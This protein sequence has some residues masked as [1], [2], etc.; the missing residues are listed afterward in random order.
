MGPTTAPAIHALLELLSSTCGGLVFGTSADEGSEVGVE[1]EGVDR[2]ELGSRDDAEPLSLVMLESYDNRREI[3][4]Y[5]LSKSLLQASLC[6]SS[7]GR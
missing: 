7:S 6:N 1:P 3:I 2:C 4:T 5:I